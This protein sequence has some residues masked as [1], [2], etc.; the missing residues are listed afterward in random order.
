MIDHAHVA[1]CAGLHNIEL[2]LLIEQLHIGSLI[3]VDIAGEADHF[4][5]DI[6]QFRN[7]AVDFIFGLIQ[8]GELVEH[9]FIGGMCGRIKLGQAGF[10]GF[11]AGDLGFD[12]H[13]AFQCA[14]GF[15]RN[16]Q[17]A[18]AGAVFVEAVFCIFQIA[19]QAR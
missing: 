17:R 19:L 4:L 6:G 8:Y 9:G 2:L 12:G 3:G 1:L 14:F 18:A 7:L 10:F 15:H 11:Q 5:L 13:Q 16:I